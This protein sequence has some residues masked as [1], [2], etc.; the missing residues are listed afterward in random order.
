MGA[1][2]LK[3][4]IID[5]SGTSPVNIADPVMFKTTVNSWVNT[6]RH[7]VGCG[8]FSKFGTPFAVANSSNQGTMPG[9]N[10]CSCRP[11]EFSKLS[12]DIW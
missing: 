3:A 5:D 7:D 2:G 10:Y 12:G 11:E 8:F 4:I 1:K 9:D 6:I